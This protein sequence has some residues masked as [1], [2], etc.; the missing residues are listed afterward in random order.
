MRVC[1]QGEQTLLVTTELVIWRYANA[2]I[3]TNQS[4]VDFRIGLVCLYSEITVPFRYLLVCLIAHL[5]CY[6]QQSTDSERHYILI[7]NLMHWLLFIHKILYSSTCFEPQVL[8]FRRL[9]LYT[10]SIW[11]CHSLQEFVVACQ[12]TAV[13]QQTTTNSRREWQYC[14]SSWWPVSAQLCPDRP[15]QT[16]VKSDSTISCMYT[17]VSSWRWAL[18][19][20]NM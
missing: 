5:A 17:T 2:F 11:Y 14:H 6:R 12:C 3:F 16:L 15:P 9:Q 19:V 10:R 18:K 13:P 7:T 4:E 1:V 20:R 8:I